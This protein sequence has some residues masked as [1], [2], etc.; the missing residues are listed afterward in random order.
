MMEE[1]LPHLMEFSPSPHENRLEEQLLSSVEG[2]RTVVVVVRKRVENGK[3]SQTI[4]RISKLFQI[5]SMNWM[6]NKRRPM[7]F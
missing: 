4:Q 2:Y 1:P 3:E 5:L 7:P 6:K